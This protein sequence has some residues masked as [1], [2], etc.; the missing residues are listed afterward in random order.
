MKTVYVMV[1]LGVVLGAEL[2]VSCT[3]GTE[4]ISATRRDIT[5]AIAGQEF[6]HVL[7]QSRF[8]LGN[9]RTISVDEGGFQKIIGIDGVFAIDDANGAILGVPNGDSQAMSIGPLTTN[10]DDHNAFVVAYFKAAGLP[11]LEVESVHANTMMAGG[12]T[13]TGVRVPDRLVGF[14]SV[15]GRKLGGLRVVESVAWARFNKTGEAV[16]E[17]VYWPAIPGEVVKN[18]A[19]MS[20]ALADGSRRGRYVASIAANHPDVSA[21]SDG[22]VVIHH[23]RST[24]RGSVIAVASFDLMVRAPGEKPGIRHFDSAGSEIFLPDE[25]ASLSLPTVRET[26]H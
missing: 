24:T 1:V 23:S 17:G 16:A 3:S 4:T 11:D 26:S 13:P 18:A 25:T 20:T 19:V 2:F 12:M 21:T 8:H 7:A 5:P 15:I 9:G 6:R 22:A 14:S 10:S